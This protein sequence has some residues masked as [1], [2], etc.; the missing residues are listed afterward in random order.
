MEKL[1]FQLELIDKLTKPG[2]EAEAQMKKLRLQ[3]QAGSTALR[4][5]EQAM[6]KLQQAK[7]VDIASYKQLA[8]QQTQQKAHVQGL[9]QSILDLAG[10][11]NQAAEVTGTLG[12]TLAELGGVLG[13]L[14][15]VAAGFALALGAGIFE[16]AKLSIEA[17]EMKNDT[18]DALEAFQGS[19]AA[20]L[21]TYEAIEDMQ[22]SVAISQE[23]GMSLARELS[24]SGVTN[25]NA[26]KDA[27]QSIGQVESVLGSG[28]GSKIQSI[29]ERSGTTGKFKFNAKQLSG[30]G[31]SE[32]AI[33]K[34][35]GLTP[36]QLD[37]QMKAGQIT[38]ERGIAAMTKAIDEK[39]SGVA[40]KQ[41]LDIGNQFQHLKDNVMK[42]FEDVDT[43]PFFEGLHE[44][45]KVFDQ[46]TE[47]GK[48][49]KLIVTN[50][51]N[52]IF[53]VASA[54]MPYVVAFFKGLVIIALQVYIAMKPLLAQFGAIGDQTSGAESLGNAMSVIG[55]VIGFV[56]SQMVSFIQT[57]I[58]VI[59]WF[60]DVESYLVSLPGK[61]YD[62]GAAMITGL[63]NGIKAGGGAAVDAVKNVAS[64]ALDSFK[65][66][67]GIHS[68]SK[69]MAQMGQHLTGGL[70][71]GLDKGAPSA[72]VAMN[73]AVA[74]PAL[75]GGNNA[76]SGGGMQITVA[77][78]AIVITGV[79]N[80]EQLAE[81][82]PEMMADAF[83]KAMIQAGAKAA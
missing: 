21:Q 82:M 75:G 48:A 81:M 37:A 31:I 26:L 1:Q 46:S 28:A 76:P 59:S 32:S 68:P 34:Q 23:R 60:V 27:I 33:A 83:E 41:V 61:F 25:A 54:V 22:D 52:T 36:A 10:S 14:V 16:G 12:E 73:E 9:Q 6:K 78:G 56:V 20:A 15:A 45:L 17:A 74:P 80:A 30:T 39:F 69:V 11:E 53:A 8:A 2:K 67:F 79:Q 71:Q 49:L 57:G 24:A 29:I 64:S 50:V 5:T 66:I 51:F 4:Q 58:G 3:L 63:V 19:A 55:Q 44:V 70:E 40:G 13:P 43:G 47:S 42:L 38:A 62:A 35:L 65:G 72:Q 7:V 77:P 18:L